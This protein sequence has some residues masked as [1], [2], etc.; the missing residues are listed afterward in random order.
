[1]HSAGGRRVLTSSCR[2]K[3][4]STVTSSETTGAARSTQACGTGSF[5]RVNAQIND[6]TMGDLV[7][8]GPSACLEID[9]VGAEGGDSRIDISGQ[10]DERRMITQRVAIDLNDTR[11]RLWRS[12]GGRRGRR[13]GR[14]W[15][16]GTKSI[17]TLF[18]LEVDTSLSVREQPRDKTAFRT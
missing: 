2:V 7:H 16:D 17:A 4:G 13:G 18:D 5:V 15:R 11:G 8:T 3:H 12:R 14:W 10:W 9:G 6:R 1:M